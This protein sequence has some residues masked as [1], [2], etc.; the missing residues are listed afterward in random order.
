MRSLAYRLFCVRQE[1]GLRR[2]CRGLCVASCWQ[3]LGV[4]G[5]GLCGEGDTAR[6]PLSS[7]PHRLFCLQVWLFIR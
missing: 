1:R 7:H 6:V 3:G 5:G 4:G 2:R